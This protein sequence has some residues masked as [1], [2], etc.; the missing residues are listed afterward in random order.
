MARSSDI[1]PII[2]LGE[3][4]AAVGGGL[5][6]GYAVMDMVAPYTSIP[7]FYLRPNPDVSC[8]RLEVEKFLQGRAGLGGIAG[9]VGGGVPPL[10]APSGPGGTPSDDVPLQNR[11]ERGLGEHPPSSAG[12]DRGAQETSSGGYPVA[13]LP[14]T[15]PSQWAGTEVRFLKPARSDTRLQT[16]RQ[17]RKNPKNSYRKSQRRNWRGSPKKR[18]RMKRSSQRALGQARR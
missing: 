5:I 14:P 8:Y 7:Q 16:S 12:P 6:G 10:I 17:P 3:A 9:G 13:D 2:F 15:E 18:R 1:D 11:T 4:L